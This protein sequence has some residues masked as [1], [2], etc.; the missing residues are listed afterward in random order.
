M[1]SQ[2]AAGEVSAEDELEA[3]ERAGADLDAVEVVLGR[4]D[5][6][7]FAGCETCG[8]PIDREVLLREPLTRFCPTHA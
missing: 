8:A 5:R 7:T 6:G 1:T 4:L 3:L 2:Q